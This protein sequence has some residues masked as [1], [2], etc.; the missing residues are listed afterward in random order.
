M[1]DSKKI[2]QTALTPFLE[3]FGFQKKGDAWALKKKDFLL[4]LNLQ[5]SLW[6]ATD[7]INV[8]FFLKDLEQKA[9]KVHKSDI[10]FRIVKDDSKDGFAIEMEMP[11]IQKLIK[12]QVIEPII[13]LDT[14]NDVKE[15]VQH[16]PG[17]YRITAEGKELLHLVQR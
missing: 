11:L 7:Y 17:K 9:P 12:E 13:S 15:L 3:N 4:V 8:G 10:Q 1:N 5:K 14:R 2:I 16:N 6:S